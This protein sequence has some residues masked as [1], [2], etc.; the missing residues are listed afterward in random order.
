MIKSK[1][2]DLRAVLIT[3][4][5]CMMSFSLVAQVTVTGTVLETTGEPVIGATVLEKGTGVGT[6]TDIDGNFSLKVAD[7]K[8]TLIVS[9]V[10][11]ETQEVKLAGRTKVNIEMKNND[12]LLD[13]VVVVGYGTMKKS[14]LSGASATMTED[15]I[16][17]SIIT[18]IDQSFQGRV[19]G[20]TAVATSGAPGSSSSIRVRGQATINAGAEPLYVIDGVI[21]QGGG[22]SGASLGL[23]D[24]LGNGKVSSISPMSTINPADIVSMEIL[25]DASATAIYGA[26]GA[27]G[28]VLI[29]TKHGKAGDAKFS[30][31]GS[32]SWSRQ[33][34]RI[35]IMNLREFA[36][37]YNDYVTNG[38][39]TREQSRLDFSDTSILGK[40]TNWQDAI[41]QTAF[42][43]QHQVSAHGGTDKVNYYVSGGFMDQDGTIIGSS[44]KRLNVRSNLD[45]QLKPWLKI[46]M[47]TAY[48]N[49]KERLLRAE[50]NEGVITYA[51]TTPPDIPIYDVD[52]EYTSV[53]REGWTAPNPIAQALANENSIRRNKL[54]GNIYADIAPIKNLTWRTELGYDLSWSDARVFKPT[55]QLGNWSQNK[56][57]SSWQKN[58]STYWQ[59]K[60]YI[61]YNGKIDKHRFTIMVGQECWQSDWNYTSQSSTDL[62]S[63][64]INNPSL[65]DALTF[66]I[67]TGWGRTTMASFFTRETYNYDDRYGATYTYRY[68]GSSNFGPSNRWAGFHSFAIN[69]RFKNE[70]FLKDIEWLSEGK[71]R[72]GWGQ[73]GNSNIDRYLWGST[74]TKGN[75]GVGETYYRVSNIPNV[76]IKWETQEQTNVG[77]DL[78][79]FNSRLNLTVDVYQKESKDMLMDLQLPSY[80]GT[81][82]NGS[83][84]LYAPKGNFGHIRNRGLE[85]SIKA[86]PVEFKG[87]SW[88]TDFNIS[89]N[90]NELVKLMG[91][92][93]AQIIGYGQ[94]NDVVC[95]STVGKPLYQFYGYVTDGVYKDVED[96]KNS[97]KPTSYKEGGFSRNS[98]V[99][100]GDIKFKDIS[101]PEGTPDGII[102]DYDK[103]YIGNPQPKFTFGWSNTFRYKDFDLSLFITGSVGNK[104]MNYLDIS[105]SRMNN[106]WIN[107]SG[108]VKNHAVLAPIDPAKDYSGGYQ[109]NNAA[110]VYNWYDDVDN[111]YVVNS[112]TSTP[113]LAI[114]DPA[115][116]SNVISDRY[117]EDGSY[118]RIKNITLGYTLPKKYAKKMHIDNMRVS[119]NVQN[120]L[121]ITDYKGYDPEVGAST[122][123]AT[124]YS[125]GV[126]NGRYP[127]PTTVSCGLN[128]TF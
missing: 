30:Y 109:G 2:M 18:N 56:N 97:P 64:E 85:I 115:G 28:V 122:V 65:G 117:V 123:D 67:G 21:F 98:G 116:N 80:M 102:D 101:G 14:D 71:I 62:P 24:A 63:N 81:L 42:Q 96:I 91:T 54:T 37:Y 50:G 119:V 66:K 82:G 124:G 127:S 34:K 89:W 45:A 11:L 70:S 22:Q 29:T 1:V 35:D 32:Y 72:A 100:P 58:N 78:G 38:W 20:V 106:A 47:N 77:L 33:G 113:R 23:G 79:F 13:E 51:L 75:M 4:C 94:W 26:Q 61:N 6:T 121:T 25:K 9:Y 52:G 118:V 105:L 15:A 93:N 76:G 90:K 108:T 112:E 48:T 19:A 69:W 88:D 17:G 68:D 128:L 126:D 73:T 36:E 92:A 107:Q 39:I 5:L 53:V 83:S 31:D 49:T 74:V 86:H 104:I 46:G 103:T 16:K 41:F 55:L 8:A 125:F 44:F 99:W 59:L 10:G 114:G 84:R 60:N 7:S 57:S 95:V 110:M 12:E 87:F 3:L 43:H 27:N 111:I 40:G 120:I